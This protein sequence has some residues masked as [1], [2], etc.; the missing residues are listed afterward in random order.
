MVRLSPLTW[1]C[2]KEKE[3]KRI[4]QCGLRHAGLSA[5]RDFPNR[6]HHKNNYPGKVRPASSFLE[7]FVIYHKSTSQAHS[8]M[9][10]GGY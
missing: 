6:N 1:N 4:R 9:L 8:T 10:Q 2:A 3:K 7:L 5:G